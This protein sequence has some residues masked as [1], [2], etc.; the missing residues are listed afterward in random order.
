LSLHVCIITDKEYLHMGLQ[1][2][3]SLDSDISQ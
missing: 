1:F 2:G 3:M